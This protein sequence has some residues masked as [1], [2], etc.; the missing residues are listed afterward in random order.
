MDITYHQDEFEN[1]PKKRCMYGE[2]LKKFHDEGNLLIGFVN[3]NGF[4][5]ERRKEKIRVMKTLKDYNFDIIGLSEVN[6]HW[7]LVIPEEY[8][9]EIISGHWETSNSVLAHNPEE[10]ATKVWK[11]VGC[12]QINTART[13]PKVISIG[14]ETSGLSRWVCSRY[15]GKQNLTLWV[16]SKFRP[17]IKSSSGVQTT[18][19]KHKRYIYRKMIVDRLYMQF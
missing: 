12:I 14:S 2:E 6:I 10:D 3:I 15:C 7:P 4:K 17:C 11:S 8:W 5:E 16:I 9:E 19:Y 18:Y 1:Y 13:T